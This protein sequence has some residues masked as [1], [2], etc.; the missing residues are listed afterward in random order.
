[1]A[2]FSYSLLVNCEPLSVWQICGMPNRAKWAL[3]LFITVAERVSWS[4]ST[5]IQ[6]E[7]W[8]GFV[9]HGRPKCGDFELWFLVIIAW[10]C[11]WVFLQVTVVR[12]NAVVIEPDFEVLKIFGNVSG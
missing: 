10:C 8:Q 6:S 3:V 1:M 7:K 9:W 2:K 11:L 4:S 12:L 5:S